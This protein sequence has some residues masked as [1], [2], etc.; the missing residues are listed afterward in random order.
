M[1][2]IDTS[3]NARLFL[4]GTGLGLQYRGQE[5][6]RDQFDQRMAQDDQQFAASNSLAR[7]R[8]GLDQSMFDRQ[9]EMQELGLKRDRITG[10]L[11]ADRFRAGLMP[12][13]NMPIPGYGTIMFTPPGEDDDV[14]A[15]LDQV[16]TSDDA[17]I[18]ADIVKSR[19]A[20]FKF[21]S[22][23]AQMKKSGY[24][25]LADPN[26][27][28]GRMFQMIEASQDP[29]TGLKELWQ[30][31][32]AIFQQEIQKQEIQRMQ[33]SGELQASGLSPQAAVALGRKGVAVEA[34]RNA[35]DTKKDLV[36]NFEQNL[37]LLQDAEKSEKKASAKPGYRP[38]I[39]QASKALIAAQNGLVTKDGWAIL[40]GGQ[41]K[42][43]WVEFYHPSGRTQMIDAKV[44]AAGGVG[45]R[46]GQGSA[47]TTSTTS[48]PRKVTQDDMNDIVKTVGKG[49]TKEETKAKVLAEMKRRNLTAE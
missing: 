35:R 26:T 10:R 44:L 43:G 30:V 40:N 2:Q 8:F 47:Q 33:E 41:P 23:I 42:D 9:V 25:E 7:D 14:H 5:I 32:D 27:P 13:G 36:G 18:F 45:G 37:K 31:R 39:E 20:R 38:R 21:R 15:M 28:T 12:R 3:Q 19:E 6:Q 24:S 22:E 29:E 48:K 11:M 16:D 49:A 1:S 17:K 34:A 46:A 4:Q